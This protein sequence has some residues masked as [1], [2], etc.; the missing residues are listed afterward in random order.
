[1]ICD[2]CKHK[3]DPMCNKG[4]IPL[5]VDFDGKCKDYKKAASG[6]TNTVDIKMPYIDFLLK[7]ER[8]LKDSMVVWEDEEYRDI[9]EKIARELTN[10]NIQNQ[11]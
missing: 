7:I 3:S 11:D 6:L 2:T 10:D 1:M 8:A 4:H 9:A 5:S